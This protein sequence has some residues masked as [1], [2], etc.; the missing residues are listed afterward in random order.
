MSLLIVPGR[1]FFPSPFSDILV[2]SLLVLGVKPVFEGAGV[3]D[4][5]VS[6]KASLLKTPFCSSGLGCSV[7]AGVGISDD[8]TT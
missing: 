8:W 3:V 5:G 6:V 7:A 4:D 1:C 2:P